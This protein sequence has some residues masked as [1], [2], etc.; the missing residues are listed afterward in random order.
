MTSR[1]KKF[2]IIGAGLAGLSA[3]VYAQMNDYESEIFEM[4][5]LPGGVCTGWNRKD[6]YFDGC[7]E[8]LV[9]SAP[10]NS[11][12]ELFNQIGALDASIPI[13]NHEIFTRVINIEG[14]ELVVYTDADKFGEH[15]KEE[16]VFFGFTT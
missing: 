16:K 14:Q 8:W 2:L 3:G 5:S 10:G 6:Y 9:G 15:L 13:T 1:K 11:F 12:N 7:I 4:H